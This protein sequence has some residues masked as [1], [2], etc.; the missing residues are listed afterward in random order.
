C[1]D[2]KFDA[3]TTKDYYA[4]AGYLES[5]RQQVAFIDTPDRREEI[6]GRMRDAQN[7]ARKLAVATTAKTLMDR[8]KL[9][10][11]YMMGAKQAAAQAEVDPKVVAE[12]TKGMAR[13]GA[14]RQEHLFYAWQLLANHQN[15]DSFDAVRKAVLSQL[16]AQ[17]GRVADAQKKS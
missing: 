7:H 8:C 16:K 5:S 6:L 14:W 17:A 15:E 4:L 11:K 12:W 2:H 13:T 9:L 10:A 1:H 3:I